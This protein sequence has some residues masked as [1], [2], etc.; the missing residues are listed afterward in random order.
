MQIWRAEFSPPRREIAPEDTTKRQPPDWP[1][2]CTSGYWISY[3]DI[4][5][6]TASTGLAG[7]N[8]VIAGL[9]CCCLQPTTLPSSVAI[10]AYLPAPA[11]VLRR[12]P[13]TCKRVVR[14]APSSERA[15]SSIV[16][17]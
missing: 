5:T 8:T 7:S 16:K 4:C 1:L 12:R 2:R 6:H 14:A 17:P 9:F 10:P 15:T 13:T 11:A 3:Y